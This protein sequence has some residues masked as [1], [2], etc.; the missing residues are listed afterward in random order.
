MIYASAS[1]SKLKR[2]GK[3]RIS[4][5]KFCHLFVI[6]ALSFVIQVSSFAKE[7]TFE[8]TVERNKLTLGSSLQLSLTFKDTQEMPS[9][10]LPQ[11]DGFQWRYLG[12]LT[13]FSNINGKSSSSIT[14]IYSLAPI[15]TGEFKIG[16][17]KLDYK[18][19]T[20]NSNALTITVT[21]EQA[22]DS[23]KNQVQSQGPIE[24]QD[25]SERIFLVLQPGKRQAYLNEPISL[26]LKLYINRLAVRDLRDLKFNHE[27]FSLGEFTDRGQY[28]ENI[29]EV[30]YTVREFATT[31]F[32]L[33]PGEFKLGPANLQC[34]LLVQKQNKQRSTPGFDDFFGGGFF[35]E[36]FGRY[37]AYPL[38]LKS[39]PAPITVLA[40][41]QEGRPQDFSGAVGDFSLEVSAGP[42][43]VRVGDPVTVKISVG[44]NGNFSTLNAPKLASEENFKAYDPQ[45]KQLEGKKYFEQIIMPLSEAVSEVPAVSFNFFNPR[46]ASYEVL[47]KGP[48][49]LKV[50]KA[51]SEAQPRIVEAGQVLTPALREEKVGQDIVYIKAQAG[52]LHRRGPLLYQNKLFLG[53]HLLGLAALLVIY[54]WSKK[55]KKLKQDTRYARQLFAPRKARRG[56]RQARLYLAQGGP[57]EFYDCL[58]ATLQEF[59]G[60][61]FHLPSKGITAGVIEENLKAKGIAIEVLN[62]ISEIFAACDMARY[63]L[64]QLGKPQMQK[65]LQQ[66][67]EVIDYLER[68]RL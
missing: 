28:Q 16:P 12:P 63:A 19:D 47:S 42:Q 17:F 21:E 55:S 59:L 7:I 6:C 23:G 33:R 1:K 58:F 45:V 30:D 39:A 31:I 38:E 32:A 53:L 61:K 9:L 4:K 34:N 27:G 40:L 56:L 35:D 29:K 15:K 66:L 20:Y 14:H 26:S 18:G 68:Q 64:S 57:K 41:P 65:A 52:K 8:A 43:E 5:L 3:L 46:S 62:Q 44:G 54:F 51:D 13:N 11:L 48:F 60:D 67:E 10:Q 49:P 50:N 22:Q 37:E 24:S 2:T 25:L 36:F